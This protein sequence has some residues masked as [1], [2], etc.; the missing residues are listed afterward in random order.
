NWSGRAI[1]ARCQPRAIQCCPEVLELCYSW[2]NDSYKLL[3][4]GSSSCRL[5]RL[6]LAGN[7]LDK[8]F[9][10]HLSSGCPALEDLELDECFIAYPKIMSST[11]KNLAIIDCTTY[12]WD[13]PLTITAQAL[14]SF[15]LTFIP[16]GS[17]W[18]GIS[19]DEMPYL[20]KASICLR[21]P[22]SH[23]MDHSSFFA[24]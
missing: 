7:F 10:L 13:H 6:H 19:L 5:R 9:I 2:Y 3:P 4:L 16:T 1:R 20:T 12:W 24:A 22:R 8:D 21:S 17:V 15:R 11:L 23:R 14:V 18:N